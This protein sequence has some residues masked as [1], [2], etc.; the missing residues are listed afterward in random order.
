MKKPRKKA[1]EP[2]VKEAAP[3]PI[4]APAVEGRKS[5]AVLTAEGE[6]RRANAANHSERYSAPKK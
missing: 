1:V 2:E 4:A 3:A 5:T 6:Q